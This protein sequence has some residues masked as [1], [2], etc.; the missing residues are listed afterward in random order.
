MVCHV[1]PGTNM[2]TT[3]FGYTWWDNESDGDAMYPKQQHNPTEEERFEIS[4]RNPEGA[5]AARTVV[6]SEISGADGQRGVQSK[7]KTTQFADFHSH[8]WLFRAVYARD[9]Q[10]NLLDARGS[11]LPPTTRRNSTRP[12]TSR[13][14]I[15]KR[16]CSAW[17][18]TSSRT[19]MAAA[20][21]TASRARPSSSIASIATA[22]SRSARRCALRV[23]AAPAG[24]THLE[25]LR[26][27]WG[28][29]RFEWRDG[30]LYQRSMVEQDKEWEVVQTLDSI[31][32]GNPHY[33]EKSRLC[34]NAAHRRR[35]PGATCRKTKRNSRTPTAA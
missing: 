1:H 34:E 33:N 2:V 29:R 20:N 35:A 17:T 27:P 21:F 18:A 23:P 10:G 24:G 6:R 13:T 4:Q 25:A 3:Y 31:T 22:R 15:W 26:T 11:Q 5:A 16:E 19:A 32:P 9:R 14:F 8:G 28:E 12:C 30:K 7:L